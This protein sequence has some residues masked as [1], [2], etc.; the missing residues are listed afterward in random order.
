MN[1]ADPVETLCDEAE[2]ALQAGVAL[3]LVELVARCPAPRR[4]R[5]AV[6]L[7][8]LDIDYQRRA[9][10]LPSREDYLSRYAEFG[11]AVEAAFCLIDPG[12]HDADAARL[13]FASLAE[14]QSFSHYQLA[15]RLGTGATCE[16]WKANDRMTDREVALK[17]PRWSEQ[18]IDQRLR[19]LR[20]ARALALLRHAGVVTLYELGRED[21]LP[22]LAIEL[23]EGGT[24]RDVLL[25]GALP[26][27]TAATLCRGVAVALDHAHQRG[28]VHRDIKPANILLR[29]DH[30]PVLT[31]FGLAKDSSERGDLTEQGDVLG[32][33]A[34]MPPEQATGRSWA[35]DERADVYGVGAVLFE[36][37][38]GVPPTRSSGNAAS[39]FRA[40][41]DPRRVLPSLPRDLAAIV[42]KATQSRPSD[43]Y[44]S[45]ADLAAD[46]D[47]FLDGRAVVARYPT[48]R[49]RLLR[50]VTTIRSAML[51]LGISA[52]LGV[53]VAAPFPDGK[54]AVTLRVDPPAARVAFVS[55]GEW[56][57]G[58]EPRGVTFATG[59]EEKSA[60]LAPGP[61]YVLAVAPD[62][63]FHEVQRY[64]PDA[65]AEITLPGAYRQT[66]RLSTGGVRLK[67]IKLPSPGVHRGMTRIAGTEAYSPGGRS[68]S[69]DSGYPV[70]S[71]DIDRREHHE[72]VAGGSAWTGPYC[73]AVDA[74]ER[75]GKR[76]PTELEYEFAATAR[77]RWRYPWGDAFPEGS[78][79]DAAVD[80]LAP[81]GEV[82]GLVSGIAEW[83]TPVEGLDPARPP[84]HAVVRGGD[85]GTVTGDL[86][87][88]VSSCDP[89]SRVYLPEVVAPRGV[90][91]RGVRSA[92]PLFS[93]DQMR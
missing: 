31:D 52:V 79:W 37:I 13:A 46:L 43:R 15:R 42:D 63:R 77:G 70:A 9:G 49:R 83:A 11:V 17:I 85:N 90:G 57:I 22:Y 38:T 54:R 73:D 39:S 74:A 47:R 40:G 26:S 27:R 67:A 3:D 29:G 71:F 45:A 6:E 62:G 87:P 86:R 30:E 76:L 36:A 80:R 14:G 44:K 93:Y 34:Y 7:L 4:E 25:Q 12:A 18:S 78:K 23:V 69:L 2:R 55:L 68:A 81:D 88:T 24:L 65:D 35:A 1:D 21:S 91:F 10:G 19:F 58:P 56:G 33:L 32:T 50:R 64:V 82:A 92:A 66:E 28:V 53:V 60:R 51:V 48:L 8:L 75:A 72:A 61:Y 41:Q 84:Q 59:R 16:V 5:L 20:E 89:C